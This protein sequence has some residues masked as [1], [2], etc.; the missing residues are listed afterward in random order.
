MFTDGYQE[1]INRGL[2][3]PQKDSKIYY[4]LQAFYFLEN[5]SKFRPKNTLSP[6]KKKLIKNI[7]STKW[8]FGWQCNFDMQKMSKSNQELSRRVKWHSKIALISVVLAEIN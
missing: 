5:K 7:S 8:K 4:I 1:S 2:K 6:W 3:Q